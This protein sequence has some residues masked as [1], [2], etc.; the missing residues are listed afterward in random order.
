MGLH[1]LPDAAGRRWA[2]RLTTHAAI[3]LL[4]RFWKNWGGGGVN[5]MDELVGLSRS[6]TEYTAMTKWRESK[7]GSRMSVDLVEDGDM[8]GAGTP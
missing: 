4:V 1:K 5:E 6:N 7:R 3:H 2:L 8:C